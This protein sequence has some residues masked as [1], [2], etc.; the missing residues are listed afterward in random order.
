MN[1]PAP[2]QVKLRTDDGQVVV[3][4]VWLLDYFP[5]LF[6]MIADV[7]P[8]EPDTV[9]SVSNGMGTSTAYVLRE[10][11]DFLKL[12][13]RFLTRNMRQ[14]DRAVERAE[15]RRNAH[16]FSE[17]IRAFLRYGGGDLDVDSLEFG[18]LA[19]LL[20]LSQFAHY[21]DC[22]P[23]ETFTRLILPTRMIRGT[24]EEVDNL[25]SQQLIAVEDVPGWAHR[26]LLAQYLLEVMPYA[27]R[28][29]R[30]ATIMRSVIDRVRPELV[31][32]LVRPTSSPVVCG[33]DYTF[34]LTPRGLFACGLNQRGVMEGI[35]ESVVHTFK[36]VKQHGVCIDISCGTEFMMQ[37]TEGLFYRG[38]GVAQTFAGQ[39][40]SAFSTG[41]GSEFVV[42]LQGELKCRGAN[43]WGQLGLGDAVDRPKFTNV[44]IR[45]AALSIWT[46]NAA[47]LLITTD[48]LYATGANDRGQLG[49]G[50]ERDRVQF[51]RV[52]IPGTPLAVAQGD[53]HCLVI[54]TEGVCASGGNSAGQ[55][56][57]GD[58]RDRAEFT[59]IAV[60]GIALSAA[61]GHLHSML[62][63]TEGLFGCGDGR[64]GTGKNSA[65]FLGVVVEGVP[66]AVSCGREFTML[67]TTAGLFSAGST[68]NGQ[69]G[70]G[71]VTEP[72]A[73][74]FTRVE[75]PGLPLKSLLRHSPALADEGSEK[76]RPR[77]GCRLC[78]ASAQL[79]RE[80]AFPDRVFCA[81]L[82]QRKFH[83]FDRIARFGQ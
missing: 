21:N 76:K 34:L 26:P 25:P 71:I 22:R 72:Y 35:D 17:D 49:L 29:R 65:T 60:E 81:G 4:G 11:L 9:L 70:L 77:L 78:H 7:G 23:V 8:L 58:V 51:E 1:P 33:R 20:V 75:V 53:H 79:R 5:A 56:G 82:C 3:T 83:Y 6:T 47:T 41:H 14:P 61:C 66:I 10:A 2:K 69:L 24:H 52:G 37:T 55:L 43:A 45:G 59:P 16:H 27:Q 28:Y 67:L 31:R 12:Y 73:V 30:N 38:R 42:S 62:L 40:M 80:V 18:K 74:R 63:T 44:P 32:L 36:E 39:Y 48:G 64:F 13:D 68:E 54:T 19:D 46:R 57:L 15:L 50:D